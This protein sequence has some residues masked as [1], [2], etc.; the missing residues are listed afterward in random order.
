MELLFNWRTLTFFKRTL[1]YAV[2]YILNPNQNSSDTSILL[3]KECHTVAKSWSPNKRNGKVDSVI[4]MFAKLISSRKCSH[5]NPSVNER[6]TKFALHSVWRGNR[7]SGLWICSAYTIWTSED[8][9]CHPWVP[10]RPTPNCLALL[11]L[12]TD[13]SHIELPL[14]KLV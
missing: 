2:N 4:F 14:C 6:S 13:T 8:V 3:H 7:R 5:I 10:D 9:A 1:Y 11:W 12:C